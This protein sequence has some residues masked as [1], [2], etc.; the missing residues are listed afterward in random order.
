MQ[1]GPPGVAALKGPVWTEPQVPLEWK[2]LLHTLAG[3]HPLKQ[4]PTAGERLRWVS[5]EPWINRFL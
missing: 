3:P 4:M 2:S 5:L 1:T